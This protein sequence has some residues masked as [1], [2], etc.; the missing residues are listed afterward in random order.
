MPHLPFSGPTGP[1]QPPGF[2]P[3]PAPLPPFGG[4][5]PGGINPITPGGPFPVDPLVAQFFCSQGIEPVVG[6][7]ADFGFAPGSPAPPILGPTPQPTPPFEFPPGTVIPAP[8]SPATVGTDPI[9]VILEGIFAAVNSVFT[10]GPATVTIQP[11]T[12]GGGG[13]ILPQ[14][15]SGLANAAAH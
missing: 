15:F 4:Q 7:C 8:T 14:T 13:S 5:G 10:R 6:S 2:P 12:S 1:D 11:R 9:S 3:P